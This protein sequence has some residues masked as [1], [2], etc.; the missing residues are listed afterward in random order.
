MNGLLETDSSSIS[1]EVAKKKGL[2]SLGSIGRGNHFLEIQAVDEI[3]DSKG[4]MLWF[5]RGSTDGDD[6]YWF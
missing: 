5:R 2:S 4:K 3:I 6:P 1:K